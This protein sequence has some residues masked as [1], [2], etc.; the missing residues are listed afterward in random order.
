[1]K[2]VEDPGKG[3]ERGIKRG[4]GRY[5]EHD[6]RQARGKKIW[7]QRRSSTTTFTS[8]RKFSVLEKKTSGGKIVQGDTKGLREKEVV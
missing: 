3:R 7:E 8:D 1:V 6:D 5:L 2:R 4:E